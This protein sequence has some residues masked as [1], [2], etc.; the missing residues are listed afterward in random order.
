[1]CGEHTVPP[2]Q[3]QRVT[4]TSAGFTLSEREQ[5]HEPT[6][7]EA[8]RLLFLPPGNTKILLS[9]LKQERRRGE[10]AVISRKQAKSRR[11]GR[12]SQRITCG[13]PGEAPAVEN[14]LPPLPHPGRGHPSPAARETWP[15]GI[16]ALPAAAA[17]DVPG[18]KAPWGL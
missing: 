2:Q 12:E 5:R 16:A 4:E 8:K 11:S 1:M 7:P 10:A 6:S 3:R 18:G 15:L 9:F 13:P 17:A 14:K